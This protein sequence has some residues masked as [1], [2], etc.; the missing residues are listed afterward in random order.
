MDESTFS[1][2]ISF[3]LSPVLILSFAPLPDVLTSV[4]SLDV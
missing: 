3:V 1:T 4:T 2:S